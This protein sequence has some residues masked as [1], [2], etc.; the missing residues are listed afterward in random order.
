M[1]QQ[2]H[3]DLTL[4][5]QVS[6]EAGMWELPSKSMPPVLLPLVPLVDSCA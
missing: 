1:Q 3:Q 5:L 4:L 6:E 2:A